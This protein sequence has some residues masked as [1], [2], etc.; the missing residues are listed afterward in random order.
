MNSIQERL[1]ILTSEHIDAVSYALTPL[2]RAR[3]N[4]RPYQQEASDEAVKHLKCYG[5]PFIIVMAT[6]AGK[7]LVIA[8]I[9]HKINEPILILQPSKEILEQ[10]YL[11]LKSYGIEDI[12]IYSASMNSKEIAKF[13][14]ATIGSIYQKPELFKHFKYV[15]IDECHQVNPKN[16]SGMYT[17][18]LKEIGCQSVCGL[19]ATPYR[20][21]NKFFKNSSGNMFY[22][23]SLKMVNRIH[24]FFFKK[25]VYKVETQDLIDQGYLSPIKYYCDEVDLSGLRVNSTGRDFTEESLAQFWTDQK[26]QKMAKVIKWVDEKCKCNLIFCSSIL[27]ATRAKEYLISVGI[28][29]EIVTGKTPAKEREQIIEKFRSGEIRHLVNV[30]VFTTGFDAPALDSIVLARPTMSLALYYQMVGRGVRLDPADPEKILKVIDLAGVVTRMGKVETITITK[31]DD[32]FRDK[33][34]SERG[35][36]TEVPLFTFQV[37]K[38]MGF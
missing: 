20:L 8:D 10:N 21:E 15:I 6:G 22:T 36:M 25:I 27:Q 17:K 19:T 9:C 5:K 7:S 13:T 35:T 32:G 33:V 16:I 34:V 30:G 38:E 23:S 2:H 11:K 3:Y 31:E 14:Y 29:C 4:L 1:D 37:K 18:F 26:L 24:P 28:P 12:S